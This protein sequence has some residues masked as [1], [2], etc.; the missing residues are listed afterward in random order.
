MPGSTNVTSMTVSGKGKSVGG[1]RPEPT[2]STMHKQAGNMPVTIGDAG[3]PTGAKR[4]ELARR[5]RSTRPG[6]RAAGE[7]GLRSNITRDTSRSNSPSAAPKP[8]TDTNRDRE[9]DQDAK[10]WELAK[11]IRDDAL[12]ARARKKRDD[13]EIERARRGQ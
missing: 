1:H 3:T 2:A 4:D 9:R 10:D 7:E 6:N 8:K 13:I 12:A 11:R 5:V